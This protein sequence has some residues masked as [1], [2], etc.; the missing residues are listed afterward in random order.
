MTVS[1]R[2]P[3]PNTKLLAKGIELNVD[4][5]QSELA[6]LDL[7]P[8][9]TIRLSAGNW[10]G[11]AAAVT[12]AASHVDQPNT[13]AA[14]LPTLLDSFLLQPGAT[15]SRVYEVPGVVVVFTANPEHPPQAGVQIDFTIYGR[16]D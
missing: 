12:I 11:S 9:R 7:S 14:N 3:M 10:E 16:D 8:Y 4:P 15:A 2:R 6:Q 1:Y 13:P 5:V